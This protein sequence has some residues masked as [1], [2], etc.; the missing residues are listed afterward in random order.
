MRARLIALTAY[1]APPPDRAM[2]GPL[3]R[4]VDALAIGGH[5]H[6]QRLG[7]RRRRAWVGGCPRGTAGVRPERACRASRS[8]AVA[9]RLEQR[10]AAGDDV[11]PGSPG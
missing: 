1:A 8:M 10:L 11:T 5:V 2:D 4:T 6:G 9:K 3:R 7:V